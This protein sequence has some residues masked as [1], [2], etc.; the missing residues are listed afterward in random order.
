MGLS[1][2]CT[3]LPKKLKAV[4]DHGVLLSKGPRNYPNNA[5]KKDDVNVGSFAYNKNSRTQPLDKYARNSL[6]I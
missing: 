5:E 3:L 6:M 1:K 4:R 2:L